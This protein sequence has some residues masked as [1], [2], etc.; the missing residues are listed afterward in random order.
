[1]ATLAKRPTKTETTTSGP[2]VVDDPEYSVVLARKRALVAAVVAFKQELA[3]AESV[4]PVK[5]LVAAR[6]PGR[7]VD[8]I[9]ADIVSHE[10]AVGHAAELAETAL[11]NAS[12]EAAL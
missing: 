12:R 5:A 11:L 6:Q 9:R 8:A 3:E 10:K 2:R 4:D 7:S 1:M